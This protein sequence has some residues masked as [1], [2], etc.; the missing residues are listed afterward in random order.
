MT[1]VSD[2]SSIT[3][4]WLESILQLYFNSKGRQVLDGPRDDDDDED[5]QRDQEDVAK[6]SVRVRHFSVR[7]GCEEGENL[8]S[9]LLA[10]DVQ[11]ERQG[12][13]DSGGEELHLMAKL[14]SQD[15]FC[16]HF[17]LEAGFDVREIHFY[18]T[19]M[20]ALKDFCAASERKDQWPVPPCYYAKYRQVTSSQVSS[21]PA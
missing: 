18:T 20:P 12:H 8:L 11:L 13:E 14:L 4:D 21:R 3:A 1:D 16:R 7:P 19:L 6:E 10:I 9:D 5:D 17:I 15:P 2:E